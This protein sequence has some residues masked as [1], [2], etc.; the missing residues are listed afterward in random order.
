[1]EKFMLIIREDLGRL[2]DATEREQTSE[3]QEMFEWKKRWRRRENIFTLSHW[4]PVADM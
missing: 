3:I 4:I 2:R 1:M